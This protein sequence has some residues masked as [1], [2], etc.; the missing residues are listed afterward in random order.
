MPFMLYDTPQTR[1]GKKMYTKVRTVRIAGKKG[2]LFAIH[3]KKNP[4][5][6]SPFKW[7]ATADEIVVAIG[8]R[9]TQ[10]ILINLKPNVA[11]NVSLYRLVDVWGFSYERWTPLA[12]R[13]EVLFADL[14]HEDPEKFMNSFEIKNRKRDCVGE[15]LYVQGGTDRGT[16]NWGRVGNVNGTLLWR[17]A[18]HYLCSELERTL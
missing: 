3:E 11:K 10:E 12:L 6:K 4:K 2:P 18:F 1:A 13:L 14:P 7:H 8:G 17:P 9:A 16:W 15:F 5:K